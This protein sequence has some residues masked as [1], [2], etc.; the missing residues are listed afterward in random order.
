MPNS[1]EIESTHGIEPMNRGLTPRSSRQRTASLAASDSASL[2]QHLLR[3]LVAFVAMAAT[4][5]ALNHHQT[6]PWSRSTMSMHGAEAVLSA[7]APDGSTL[8]LWVKCNTPGWPCLAGNPVD[9]LGHKFKLISRQGTSSGTTEHYR[10]HISQTDRN[11]CEIIYAIT[12]E[13]SANYS[14]VLDSQL[15]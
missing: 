7:E 14:L 11:A 12:E 2:R 9:R 10:L 6:V 15:P 5:M 3:A 4:A 8:N 1:N 13:P